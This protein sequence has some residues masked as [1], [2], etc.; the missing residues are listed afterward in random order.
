M[1]IAAQLDNRALDNELSKIHQGYL[2]GRIKPPIQ[3]ENTDVILNQQ[4]QTMMMAHL[5][6]NNLICIKQI[7]NAGQAGL[8]ASFQGKILDAERAYKLAGK[9]IKNSQLNDESNLVIKDNFNAAKGYFDYRQKDYESAREN[10]NISLE[11]CMTLINKYGYNFLEG[12][13]IHLAC[14][15]LKI[16]ACSG[17]RKKALE[18]ACYLIN[19]MQG[20]RS[21][22]VDANINLL[23]PVRHLSFTDQYFLFTQVFGE[24]AKLLA[25]CNDEEAKELV[26]LADSYIKDCNW[27]ADKQ[28]GR[29]YIWFQNKKTLLRGKIGEF[30]TES[31]NFLAEGR[32]A[33]KLLWHATVLDVLKICHNIDSE[34]SSQLQTQIREDFSNYKYLPGILRG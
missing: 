10:L 26:D 11:A 17:D 19:S 12:R 31:S 27:S 6:L 15:I 20:D 3:H 29:E 9:T 8:A 34:I 25:N 30:L 22:V 23:E 2:I 33:S 16:E 28:F 32:K 7:M 14:N 1:R 5:P 4:K 18:I 24:V 21:K 13:T